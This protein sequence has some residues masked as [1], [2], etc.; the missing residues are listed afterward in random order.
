MLNKILIQW[1][2]FDV[3]INAPLFLEHNKHINLNSEAPSFIPK[4]L[5]WMNIFVYSYEICH[6]V[7]SFLD[8]LNLVRENWGQIV[9][10]KNQFIEFYF[11]NNTHINRKQK[12]YQQSFTFKKFLIFKSTL[13]RDRQKWPKQWF[14]M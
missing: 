13:L 10:G 12:F 8:S 3:T 1:F 6:P 11:S 4:N 2:W 7:T 5:F 14:M 9:W